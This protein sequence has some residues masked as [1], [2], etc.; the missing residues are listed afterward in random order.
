MIINH[1]YKVLINDALKTG[2]ANQASWNSKRR[3]DASES[4]VEFEYG[5]A[6]SIILIIKR[7]KEHK[8]NDYYQNKKEKKR[9]KSTAIKSDSNLT[10]LR[11]LIIFSVN[12]NCLS[13]CQ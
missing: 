6:Q 8:K 11:R 10:I 5:S 13:M 4:S 12:I 1:Y 3:V 7:K 9:K 2:S